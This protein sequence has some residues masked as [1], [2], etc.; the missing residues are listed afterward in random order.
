MNPSAPET[1]SLWSSERFPEF[2]RFAGELD[3]EVLIVGGGITGLTL[4]YTL[5]QQGA[6]VGLF[7][8]RALAGGASGRNAGFLMVAAA[9]PYGEMVALW[10]RPG[11]RAMLE[12]GRRNHERIARLAQSLEID[13]GYAR[14]GSFRLARTEEEAEDQRASLPLMAADGFPCL[15]VPPAQALPGGP[16]ERFAAAFLTEED[17]EL[18]P[19]RF[20]HGLAL[21]TAK[22]GGR[23]FAHSPLLGARW[24]GGLWEARTEAGTA[25]ARALVVATNA[26]APQLCPA[27]KPVVA[28]RRGQMIATAPL[29]RI[30]APRPTYAHWGYQYWRQT[31]D[32]RLVMGGWRDLDLDGEVGYEEKLTPHIQRAIEAGLAEL[33]P[34]GAVIDH[35]WAGIMGFARDGRPLVGWLD[36]T[37]QLAICAGFTGHGMGMAASCTLDLAQILGFRPAPGISSFD[38]SR[39]TELQQPHEGITALGLATT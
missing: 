2:P 9:E 31:P 5:A 3:V 10:G 39:F 15:E 4:A 34:E 17:G 25:R 18:H 37:H 20:L 11:A 6:T 23:L 12:I 36:A 21:A 35:R 38:P 19:V 33:V 8:A 13:C 16:H 24:H 28:P 14:R 27:L 22:L 32:L 26:Y 7:E 1:L 30:V 29:A